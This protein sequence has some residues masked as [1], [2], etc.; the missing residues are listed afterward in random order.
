MKNLSIFLFFIL[1]IGC[2]SNQ[3]AQVLQLSPT[4]QI[5]FLDSLQAAATIVVDQKDMFF[6]YI[7]K[8]DMSIQM[9]QNFPATTTREEALKAY[10]TFI[11]KDVLS[12]TATEIAFVEKVFKKAYNNIEQLSSNILTDQI[13][14]IKSH[15]QQYG[16]ST[17]Y[18]RENCIVIPKYVLNEGNEQAFYNTMLHE[19]F[20][21]YSRYNPTKREALYELIGFK[22]IGD[23]TLLKMNANLRDRVLLNPDG[24]NYA[25]A[26]N[27]NLDDGTS[28]RAIPII[29]SKEKDYV[30]EKKEFFDYLG[31]NLFPVLPPF[32]R[33]VPVQ[34]D[35]NG[36]SSLNIGQLSDFQRQ[37]RDNT[38]YIIH[39]DEIMADNFQFLVNSLS[40]EDFLNRFSPEGQELIQLI[41]AVIVK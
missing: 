28:I 19:I 38:G 30:P 39:P 32:S 22:N 34:S 5:I 26:I 31:F 27:L 4:N 23:P 6:D 2:K 20:H 9:R 16:N 7:N 41:K 29:Y 18:T 35:E 10:K 36:N 14:L 21:I 40:Q 25:Y 13:K 1:I 11:Q 12:F 37:I 33:L 24:V 15:G 8:T 3:S 17:Y